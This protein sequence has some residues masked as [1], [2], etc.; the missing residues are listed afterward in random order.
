MNV[1]MMRSR[2][3]KTLEVYTSFINDWEAQYEHRNEKPADN[4]IS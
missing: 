3:K 4:I 1:E 2:E